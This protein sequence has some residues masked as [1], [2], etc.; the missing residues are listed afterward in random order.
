LYKMFPFESFRNCHMLQ[1]LSQ[2]QNFISTAE[3][4]VFIV[5]Q[6]HFITS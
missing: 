1:V 3:L 6:N 4:R 2:R 5:E